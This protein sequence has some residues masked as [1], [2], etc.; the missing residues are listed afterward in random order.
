MLIINLKVVVTVRHSLPICLPLCLSFSRHGKASV[1]CEFVRNEPSQRR[2][3]IGLP[4][5][6]CLI[7]VARVCDL[8]LWFA[9]WLFCEGGACVLSKLCLLQIKVHNEYYE[10]TMSLPAQMERL[11][12]LRLFLRR[13]VYVCLWLKAANSLLEWSIFP[14]ADL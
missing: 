10:Y 6:N 4:T 7:S 9:V 8:S 14:S 13:C 3:N 11:M 2:L 1:L 12:S 5:S